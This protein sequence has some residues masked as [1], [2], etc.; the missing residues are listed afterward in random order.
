M[1]KQL[2]KKWFI[3]YIIFI[4]LSLGFITTIYHLYSN[5]YKRDIQEL[6]LEKLHQQT[7]LVDRQLIS[8]KQSLYTFSQHAKTL[9]V[10]NMTSDSSPI[11]KLRVVDT[12]DNLKMHI[13]ANDMIEA[14]DMYINKLNILLTGTTV[15][16]E[17]YMSIYTENKYKMNHEVF[18]SL[19]VRN[20][21]S[22]DILRLDHIHRLDNPR[23]QN[24]LIYVQTIPPNFVGKSKATLIV[25]INEKVVSSLLGSDKDDDSYT[26]IIDDEDRLIYSTH[27]D[28]LSRNI[29]KSIMLNRGQDS[30]QIDAEEYIVLSE[31]SKINK[32]TYYSIKPLKNYFIS[33][34]SLRNATVISTIILTVLCLVLAYIFSYKSYKPVISILKNI[35]ENIV[36][37]SSGEFDYILD[38]INKGKKDK[39][40]L[41]KIINSQS[42]TV[43]DSFIT[44][45]INNKIINRDEIEEKFRENDII[46]DKELFRFILIDYNP[47]TM[48]EVKGQRIRMKVIQNMIAEE[49]NRDFNFYTFESGIQIA[50]IINYDEIDLENSNI[51]GALEKSFNT[52]KN[53]LNIDAFSGFSLEQNEISYLPVMYKEAMDALTYAQASGDISIIGFDFINLLSRNYVFD[54]ETE[55]RLLN[56]IKLGNYEEALAVIKDVI[57]INTSNNNLRFESIQ[58]LFFDILSVIVKSVNSQTQQDILDV[59]QP[60]TSMMQ[61]KNLDK[62]EQILDNILLKMCKYN[63]EQIEISRKSRLSDDV[64][65]YVMENYMNIDLNIAHLSNEFNI[66]PA[67]LSK[68]YKRDTGE[69][70]MDVVNRIRINRAKELLVGTSFTITEISLKVGYLYSNAFIRFF[71]KQTGVTPGKYRSVYGE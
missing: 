60:I 67:Y 27:K 36:N 40:S 1:K 29:F 14:M 55:S 39:A 54:F 37:S 19:F 10:I 2:L 7:L 32:W 44:Q 20:F 70:L 4:T 57:N 56:N 17:L 34:N 11:N 24:D 21:D 35:D 18:K 50:F 28:D 71:K 3:T 23:K 59:D 62:M 66:T 58:C 49:I 30:F 9:S 68:I 51:N 5:S 64:T 53:E 63:A 42:K 8:L 31:Y 38:A 16:R 45:V 25:K 33:I 12:S 46:F 22:G 15:Y 6:N 61:S 48:Q 47:D 13:V 65:N 52:I 26:F 69:I 41:E 43:F